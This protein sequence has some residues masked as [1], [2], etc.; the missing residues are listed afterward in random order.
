MRRC[1]TRA[2]RRGRGRPRPNP[3]ACDIAVLGGTGFIGAAV[4][5]AARDDGLRVSVMAR[6]IRNLPAAFHDP[7]VAVHRGDIA[8]A[9]AVAR[10]IAGAP[11]VVN[12][13]HGGG[14][15][16]FAAIRAAMVGGAETVAR[17]CLVR[18]VRLVHVGSI[19]ALYLGPQTT[20]ITGAT[21]PDPQ[22]AQRADYAR[23]KAE[24]DRMLLAMAAGEGLR[25][26][27]LRPGIVVGDG[28]LAVPFRGRPLSERAALHRL[29]RRA[30]P[31]AFRAGG[32]CGRRHP[33]RR[34][35]A[36][37]RGAGLQSGGR[38]AAVGA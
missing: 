20:P 27:I 37:D 1:R 23:A 13:A 15:G 24:C 19:A 16:N 25:L 38:R 4:V 8:D 9:E 3:A 2:P 28:G 26:V 7:R 14:G 36:G 30:Q 34:A 33:A 17:A 22:A 12:L 11:V 10:A 29:E 18:G 32:R 31:A 21:P 6:S 35:H 5:R